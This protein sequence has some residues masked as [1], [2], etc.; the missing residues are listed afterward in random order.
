MLQAIMAIIA[1]IRREADQAPDTE[2]RRGFFDALDL[3]ETDIYEEC[4]E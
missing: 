2:Y 4:G 1:K 3:V